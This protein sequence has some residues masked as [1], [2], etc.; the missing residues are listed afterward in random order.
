MFSLLASII[1]LFRLISG[2]MIFLFVVCIVCYDMEHSRGTR[3][4]NS[5]S[6]GGKVRVWRILS[7]REL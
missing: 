5:H 4:H 2:T 7:Q 6:F 3:C 1:L